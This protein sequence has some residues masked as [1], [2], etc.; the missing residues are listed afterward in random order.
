MCDSRYTEPS[1]VLARLRALPKVG[2]RDSRP[3]E[4]N[5]I[6][7]GSLILIYSAC[8]TAFDGAASPELSLA[9]CVTCSFRR[10]MIRL[11][12]A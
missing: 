11:R 3:Q 4:R 1:A 6:P 5:H 7:F 12:A 10:R 8:F 2:L 9:S